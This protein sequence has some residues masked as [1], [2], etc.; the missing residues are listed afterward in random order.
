MRRAAKAMAAHYSRGKLRR[1]SVWNERDPGSNA[2]FDV[3][4]DAGLDRQREPA[5]PMYFVVVCGHDDV[6]LPQLPALSLF[7]D[8]RL[9]LWQE[10]ARVAKRERQLVW[11]ELDA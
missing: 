1:S 3:L 6:P 4:T 2:S 11:D 9:S 10:F 5:P 7:D 8:G